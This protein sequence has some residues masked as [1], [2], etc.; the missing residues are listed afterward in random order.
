[1]GA[2]WVLIVWRRVVGR[3]A[4]AIFCGATASDL[5]RVNVALL[6]YQSAS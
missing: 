1:M 6:D 5:E 2:V 4:G 3:A